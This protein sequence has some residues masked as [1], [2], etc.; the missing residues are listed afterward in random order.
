M[1]IGITGTIG[2][3]KGTV[4][5]Y[6]VKARGFTHYSARD[7]WTEEILR[8]GWEVNRDTMVIVANELRAEHGA[9]F[10][11]KRAMEKA[12][13]E[14]RDAVIESIRTVGE[15]E[16]IKKGGELWAVDADVTIRYE[17]A[18]LRGSSTDKVSFE[19]FKYDEEVEWANEDPT[20]QNLKAVIEM[21]DRVF[22]NNGT[23]EELHR[24]IE[25]AFTQI[26]P[27]T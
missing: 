23:L 25:A 16:E 21:A 5:D 24:Q 8:R 11:A 27:G 3:G 14:G 7:V 13:K 2:A 1:I 4:V 26:Q 10:F 17:R 9:E 15:A 6:L 18:I 19:K 20:K 22:I 12:R